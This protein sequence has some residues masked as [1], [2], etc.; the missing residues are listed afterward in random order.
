MALVMFFCSSQ[1]DRDVIA[2]E[3]NRRFGDVPVVGCTTAGE[4]GTDG[5]VD[6]SITGL[7][8]PSDGWVAVTGRLEKL[9]DFTTAQGRHFPE[10]LLR[11]LEEQVPNLS[12]DDS[13]AFLM[14]DGLSMREEPVGHSVQDVLG[15]IRLVGGSAGDD[16]RFEQTWIFQEGAFRTDCAVLVL[17]NTAYEFRL[18]KTQHFNSSD[19]RLVVTAADAAQRVVHEINGRPAVAEYARLIGVPQETLGPEHFAASPIV[20]M[21]DGTDYVRSI[22][23]ANPDGSLTFYS[24]I[25]EGL[26]LRVA[27][28]KSMLQDMEETFSGLRDDLGEPQ[29]VITCDCILRNLEMQRSGLQEAASEIY[30]DNHAVGFSTYGEQYCGVHVNQTLTG[31]A[32]GQKARAHG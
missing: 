3:M 6:K 27:K 14:V 9:Q 22:Q 25:D 10:A 28:G 26:V 23:K 2:E 15:N 12:E 24:A 8:F 4:I 19:E 7:S 30:R 11:Q 5:Y 16:L 31:I 1:Y 21:L 20:I 18:F 32:I 29:A 17:M 13:F